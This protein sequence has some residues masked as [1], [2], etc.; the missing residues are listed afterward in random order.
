MTKK[1]VISGYYG[2]GNF[3]DEAILS[4]LIDKLKKM[5]H[6]IVVLSSNPRKTSM[7]YFVNSINSFDLHQ[8]SG[9]LKHSDV[10]ISGGGSLLQDVT[11]LKSLVYYLW[12]IFSA[13]RYKK[14]VLIFAQG[15]GPIRNKIAQF[16][17]AKMLKHCDYV[18]VRDHK[19]QKMLEWMGVDS[20]LLCDPIFSL[21]LPK[22]K[23]SGVLGVQLREFATLN[24]NLLNKLARQI[25]KEFH[26]K[27]I[28]IYSFQDE[29]DLHICRKFMR[30]LNS[31]NPNIETE[32][33][34]VFSVEEIINKFSRLDYLIAMRFHALVVAL[35]M[36]VKSIAINYDTKVEKLALEA[37]VPILSMSAIE[38]LD[39]LFTEM[40][41]LNQNSLI[42][43]AN[44]NKFDWSRFTKILAQ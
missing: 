39:V 21:D 42:T 24:D 22:A 30:I 29:L 3:G 38:D 44:S 7:E 33:V 6:D 20:D 12:V 25:V 18:S 43:F 23:S 4:L 37:G 15:I 31:L 26:D 19:S 28:E 40:K 8:V 27:K 41:L 14:K 11:S 10:L 36:G 2:F 32:V 9:L 17:T 34:S 35:K 1:V 13:L 5:G 16:V